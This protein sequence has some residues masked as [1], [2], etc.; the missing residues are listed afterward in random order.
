MFVY[1]FSIEIAKP[2]QHMRGLAICREVFM[3]P[4][5]EYEVD[6]MRKERGTD[7]RTMLRLCWVWERRL[8]PVGLG[9]EQ[10]GG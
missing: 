4:E 1:L 9:H 10:N 3:K 8:L 6:R 7:E 5:G 2:M